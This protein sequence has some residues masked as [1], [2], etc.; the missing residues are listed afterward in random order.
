MADAP[1]VG[2][3]LGDGAEALQLEGVHQPGRPGGATQHV[4]PLARRA[5]LLTEE[6]Q[7]RRPHAAADHE[8]VLAVLGDDEA[9]PD[10]ANEVDGVVRLHRGQ[11]RRARPPDVEDDLD[12]GRPATGAVDA[13]DREGAAQDERSVGRRAEVHE[14]ARPGRLG[15]LWRHDRERVVLLTVLAVGQDLSGVMLHRDDSFG[16]FVAGETPVCARY[17]CKLRTVR[18]PRRRA[19]MPATVARTASIVVT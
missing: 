14:L 16:G 2:G 15:Y 12:G 5:Q 13:A 11:G 10:G 19:S 9:T 3:E 7:G 1:V 4:H 6:E 8:A 18:P 17:S